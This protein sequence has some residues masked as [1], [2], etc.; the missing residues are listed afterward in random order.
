MALYTE[1]QKIYAQ[2]GA[3]ALAT[4]KPADASLAALTTL[5]GLRTLLEGLPDAADGNGY[6]ADQ[7]RLA[8]D[9]L[10]ACAALGFTDTNVAAWNTLVLALTDFAAVDS[11]ISTKATSSAQGFSH[12]V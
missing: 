12:F 5:A 10:V 1:E 9:V 3:A 4:I 8:N 11:T 6:D 2:Q 7:K